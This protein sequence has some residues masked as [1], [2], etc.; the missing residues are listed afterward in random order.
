MYFS[1]LVGLGKGFERFD[2]HSDAVTEKAGR[3]LYVQKFF[4]GLRKFGLAS[5]QPGRWQAS[6]M[7]HTAL[8]WIDQDRQRPFFAVV[9]FFDVHEPYNPPEPYRSQF[10]TPDAAIGKSRLSRS[11]QVFSDIDGYDG[12]IAYVDAQINNFLNQL[13][14]RSLLQNTLIVITSD[15][16][17]SFGEH[18][19]YGHGKAL[20]RNLI[21][22]PLIVKW[23]NHLPSGIRVSK[24]VSTAAIPATIIEW[25]A[26]DTDPMF[27]VPS[28]A[29][30]WTDPGAAEPLPP[31]SELSKL[32]P[33][34]DS[35]DP[36]RF[37]ASKSLVTDKWHYMTHEEFGPELYDWESDPSETNNLAQTAAGRLLVEKLKSYLD[38]L[39]A[40]ED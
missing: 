4:A 22:V 19:V 7:A 29:R 9:N 30:S 34:D 10:S 5:Y 37:G 15:H 6:D 31:L 35:W 39:I 26:G 38:G 8:E 16:G 18:R 27:A 3:T 17:Q 33:V 11:Q 40:K 32:A 14:T 25:V 20:Y 1:P 13:D 28:I 12:A 21:H 24:P 2:F 36:A 23:P